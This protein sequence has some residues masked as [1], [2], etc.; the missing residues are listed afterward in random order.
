MSELDNVYNLNHSI[1]VK[2]S[3]HFNLKIKNETII[4]ICIPT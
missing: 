3:V 2:S 4:Q 1:R